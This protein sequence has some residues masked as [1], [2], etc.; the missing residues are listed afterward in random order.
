MPYHAV[1]CCLCR[2]SF[3]QD[4]F[5]SLYWQTKLAPRSPRLVAFFLLVAGYVVLHACLYFLQVP[6]SLPLSLLSLP[7]PLPSL[8]PI[9]APLCPPYD[10]SQVATLTVVMNSAD[11]ALITVLV[12]N[13]FSE[14]RS[15]VFKKCVSLLPVHR[16]HDALTCL[17][18]CLSVFSFYCIACAGTS[19]TTSSKCRART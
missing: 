12:L 5:D 11:T 9:A 14:L 7:L 17:P 10:A 19:P 2:S 13:N 1:P 16:P 8:I 6:P 15:F 3:G 4:A 18:V